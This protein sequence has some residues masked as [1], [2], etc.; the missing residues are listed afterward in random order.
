[1]EA[2]DFEFEELGITEAVG[3]ALHGFDL[4]V[5]ALQRAGR[6]A[7]IVV[8]QNAF[9]VG[10][11][12]VGELL[13]EADA[14][15]SPVRRRLFFPRMTRSMRRPILKARPASASSAVEPETKLAAVS[16]TTNAALSVTASAKAVPW[17]E[18][19]G[20]W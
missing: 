17:L 8:I 3:L 2:E 5:G 9:L 15:G 16:A 20:W 11:E 10:L 13:Q 7:V 14:G 12:R 19:A 18:G 4:V 1:M 6:D